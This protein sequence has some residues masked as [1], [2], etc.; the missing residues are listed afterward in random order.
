MNIYKKRYKTPPSIITTDSMKNNNNNKTSQ[1][2]FISICTP[3]FNRRPFISTMIQCFMNQTYPRD[4]MEWIIVDDGTDKV[5]DIIQA[6]NIPQIKYVKLPSIYP[7]GKKRNYMHSLCKG[8]FIVYMDDDDYYPPER[9]EHAIT[10]LQKNPK[11]MVAGSS[12]IFIYFKH[13]Q[14]MVQFGP[15]GPNHA[16]AGTFA[17]RKEL[18]KTT[19][20][21]DDANLAEERAFLKEYT[22]PMVQLDPFKTILVFSHEHNTFDKRR[23]LNGQNK[24]MHDSTKT[25]EDFMK[26]LKEASIK[27]FFMEGIDAALRGYAPGLPAMKPDVIRQTVEIEKKRNDMMQQTMSQLTPISIN[28]ADGTS[29]QLTMEEVLKM[30]QELQSNMQQMGKTVEQQRVYMEYQAEYI[31]SFD[32]NYNEIE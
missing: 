26:E 32:P 23:L 16:T 27:Q 13:I 10:S 4:R 30:V 20:Y 1:K 14:K 5:E 8:D 21:D 3:T 12:I 7:L 18:L 17:F 19:K 15:Y 24:F 31:R 9:V 11:A 22:V 28:N 6:A 25:V 29:K 2:P